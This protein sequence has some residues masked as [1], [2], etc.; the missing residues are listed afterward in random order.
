[1]SHEKSGDGSSISFRHQELI[2]PRYSW[3]NSPIA[4]GTVVDILAKVDEETT[5][6]GNGAEDDD[7]PHFR[8]HPGVQ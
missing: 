7:E 1:M 5:Q 4:V 8:E 2:V 3:K 6:E